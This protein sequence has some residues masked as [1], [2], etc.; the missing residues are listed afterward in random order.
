MTDAAAATHFYDDNLA[1]F[2]RVLAEVKFSLEDAVER[3]GIKTHSISARIKSRESFFEKIARKSVVEPVYKV[4]DIVGVRVVCLFKS[5]LP[6]L[7]EVIREIFDTFDF[8]DKVAGEDPESFGYMSVH[9][10][11]QIRRDHSGPRYDL[12]K[13]FP[14][15]I[16]C[17]TIA[18]DAWA[19]ISHYLAYK[20]NASIP[21]HLQRDFSALSGLF[22]IADR[23]FE[24]FFKASID[25]RN[26]AIEN[27][28]IGT[29]K[30]LSINR[31]SMGAYLR[32]K[33]PDREHADDEGV[34]DLVEQI[35]R[36]SAYRT[37]GDLE[38]VIDG[39]AER[40]LKSEK[41]NPPF[42]EDAEELVRYNDVG[43]VRTSLML[44][45]EAFRT[46]VHNRP[47]G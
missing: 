28:E 33:Y 46:L 11:C 20:G 15:E 5:D 23:H 27:A 45:D 8:D 24:S 29:V 25:S 35:S 1:V 43:I 10:V 41:E 22:Y 38:T 42:S 34:S 30:G 16:Q 21:D 13:G 4:N 37:I 6:R 40:V 47:L 2:H 3:Y 19:N 26:E 31:D 17:R 39:V 36:I 12:L 14:F 18:M 7:D 9:Y 32:K 44:A